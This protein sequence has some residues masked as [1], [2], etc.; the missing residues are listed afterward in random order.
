VSA[1]ARPLTEVHVVDSSA[2]T[3][4]SAT[5]ELVRRIAPTLC[6]QDPAAV[7]T[8]GIELFTL[9]PELW[10]PVGLPGE[11]LVP[12]GQVDGRHEFS[13]LETLRIA[14]GLVDLLHAW[15][16]TVGH[17]TVVYDNVERADP[18]E[19]QL[20]AVAV[21]SVPAEL[22]E[23]VVCSAP[24]GVGEPLAAELRRH[25]LRVEVPASAPA[26][27]RAGGGLVTSR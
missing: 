27:D 15:A 14:H 5:S 21:R 12:L 20:L 18:T 19:W 4:F 3:P 11:N 10:A 8:H 16:A 6:V 17:S 13:Q 2:G 22:V 1:G 7:R 24:T 25:A 9:A 26:S 23:L